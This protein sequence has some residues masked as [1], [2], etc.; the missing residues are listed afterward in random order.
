MDSKKSG[1]MRGGFFHE[2]PTKN[3]PDSG[4]FLLI[5]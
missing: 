4:E 3:S 1:D 2:S 5:D